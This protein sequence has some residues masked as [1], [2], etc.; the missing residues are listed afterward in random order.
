[1]KKTLNDWLF[2]LENR[3]TQEIQLG[4]ARIKQVADSLDLLRP[5]AKVISVAGTNGKGSTVACLE[6]IY[7]AS[8]YQVGSYTS[9]HL[10][11]FNERIKINQK[12]I[13]D[14]ELISIF[15]FIDKSR[16]DIPITYFE[17][18]T[19]AALLHFKRHQLDLIILE[20][21]LGGRLDATNIIDNDLAIITTIDFDHQQQLGNTLEAIGFEK[22]GILRAKRPFIYA[23]ES[24]PCSILNQAKLQHSLLFRKGEEYQYELS[25]ND[26]NFQYQ[27]QKHVLKQSHMHPNSMAAAFMATFCLQKELPVNACSSIKAINNTRISGR[28]QVFTSDEITTIVDVSHNPQ[29]IAYLIAYIKKQKYQ[30]LHLVFAALKDKDVALMCSLIKPFVDYWYPA[31]LTGKRALTAQELLEIVNMDE[32]RTNTCHN[33]PAQAYQSAKNQAKAGDLIVVCGSFITVAAVLFGNLVGK[34]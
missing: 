10:L 21:G 32:I 7:L 11:Y 26:I 34:V 8:G 13:H 12:P 25:D 15:E 28:L 22:A 1:M 16:G 17:M 29:S 5:S 19:L 30:S 24:P 20:I 3:H 9:P 23:D 4:L 27:N 14:E 6:S 33:D 2:Y 18:A 31:Q